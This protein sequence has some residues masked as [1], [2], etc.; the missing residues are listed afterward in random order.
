VID[1][2]LF[3]HFKEF[4]ADQ[5]HRSDQ[6]TKDFCAELPEKLGELPRLVL[7][8]KKF[9]DLNC[10]YVEKYFNVGIYRV[11]HE[12]CARLRENVP[13]VKAHRY[14]PKH[15]YPKLNGYGDNG[16]RSLKL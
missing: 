5:S 13:F 3:L 14:N 10:E 15:V 12:K 9:L 7:R 11:S 2:N 4:L 6:E 16:E 8:Y 1:H